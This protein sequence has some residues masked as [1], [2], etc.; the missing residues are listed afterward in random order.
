MV[1]NARE[2]IQQRITRTHLAR[3][4][5]SLLLATLLWGWVT[6]LQDPVDTD[7]YAEI[8]MNP[9]ELSGTIQIVTTLPRATVTLTDVESRLEDVSRSDISV[10]LDT[11]DIDGPGTYEVP[12]N[13]S[14][15]TEIRD[16]DV[17]PDTISVQVEEEVS[18]NFPLIVENQVRADDAR[19]I[20]DINPEVSEVTV[21]GTE[22]AVNRIERV[23]LPVS[24]DRETSN[25]T[26]TI[27]PYAVDEENQRIQEVE[28]RPAQV[29]T[30][31]ELET[32]GKTVS[33]VPQLTGAPAEGYVVQ[34]QIAVPP[35][36]I[37]DGPAEALESI[38][39]VN[40]EPV[41]I[42]GATESV[43]QVVS[44][45]DLPDG[46]TVIDPAENVVEVRVSI[47]TSSGTANLIPDMPIQIENERNGLTAEI[48]PNSVDIS[49]SA[50]TETLTSLAPEDINV[51][52]DVSGLGTGVYTLEPEVEVPEEVSVTRLAPEEVVVVIS[53]ESATPAASTVLSGPD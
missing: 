4:G 20:V 24:I 33:V 47:G 22:S 14:T 11:S 44:L 40:T 12:V 2:Y 51:T 6:Q 38:L 41:D 34:Q 15:A 18:R 42:S 49:V 13:A 43:S 17:S 25:F 29:R 39:F 3:F 30:E 28:I 21:T 37:V 9:P 27:E 8:N 45:E 16:I 23:V 32:R 48:N 1:R 7:R 35:T 5:V 10:S 50:S 19:R 31:V 53:D 26:D 46:V 52:V 36:V